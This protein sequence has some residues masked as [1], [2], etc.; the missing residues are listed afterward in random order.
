M[1][2]FWTSIKI[3]IPKNIGLLQKFQWKFDISE[4]FELPPE[5][6]QNLEFLESLKFPAK[7]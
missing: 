7:F 4:N 5:F 6:L 1:K 3:Q 2:I